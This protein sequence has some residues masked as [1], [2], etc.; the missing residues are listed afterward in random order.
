MS[1]NLYQLV[2]DRLIDIDRSRFAKIVGYDKSG[3]EVY[4]DAA[5]AE[6]FTVVFDGT[7][8]FDKI[9]DYAEAQRVVTKLY[10][11]FKLGREYSLFQVRQLLNV[12]AKEGY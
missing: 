5:E 10:R 9:P 3:V 12:S 6:T 7:V 11:V 8:F 1:N 2:P 4:P